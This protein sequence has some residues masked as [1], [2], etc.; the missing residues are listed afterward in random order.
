MKDN[1]P[2]L[3]AADNFTLLS[4]LKRIFCRKT[5]Y[6][7]VES[8]KQQ[9]EGIDS[10]KLQFVSI[11][12]PQPGSFT[13]T[14]SSYLANPI[15]TIICFDKD[16][17]K[18]ELISSPSIE[19]RITENSKKRTIF[20]FDT[21]YIENS[22]VVGSRSRFLSLK[23]AIPLENIKLIEVQDGGKRFSYK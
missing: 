18:T 20:Y 7:P 1:K 10:S 13:T 12:M 4:F 16:N 15:Y 9:F 11:T 23:K 2:V 14:S 19:M 22:R 3:K 5:Y 8:F 6:I 21:V 17:N